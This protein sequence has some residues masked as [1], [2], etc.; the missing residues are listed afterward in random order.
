MDCA[1]PTSPTMPLAPELLSSMYDGRGVFA[2]DGKL[3]RSRAR[4][5]W[6]DRVHGKLPASSFPRRVRYRKCCGSLCNTT[7]PAPQLAVQAALRRTL[8][9]IVADNA[10]KGKPRNIA[11]R[12]LFIAIAAPSRTDIVRVSDGVARYGRWEAVQM[13][14]K[15]AHRLWC[16]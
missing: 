5:Q 7:T 11:D 13:Y 14:A 15:I 2:G 1:V 12:D 16:D 4:V 9:K 10:F 6:Q 3:H 8:G